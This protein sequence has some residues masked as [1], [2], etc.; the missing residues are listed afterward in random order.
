MNVRIEYKYLVD[1][2]LTALVLLCYQVE[3]MTMVLA[4]WVR[5]TPH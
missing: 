1:E 5:E 3:V 2:G 4:R